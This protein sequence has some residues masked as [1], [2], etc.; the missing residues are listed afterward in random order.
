MVVLVPEPVIVT[1][2]GV[3][4]NVQVP[5]EGNPLKMTLPVET[6]HVGCVIAP[7]TGADGLA[8]TVNE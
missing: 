8:F 2:P 4:C 5:L 3:R 6:T 7:T 1:P